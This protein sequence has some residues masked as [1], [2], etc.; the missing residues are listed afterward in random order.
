[1]AVTVV[2]AV[3]VSGQLPVPEQAP[4]QPANVE[5]PAGVAVN[6]TGVPLV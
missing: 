2:A 4:L 3:I 5:P 6:V 1:M